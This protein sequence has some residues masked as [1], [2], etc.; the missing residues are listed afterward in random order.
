M[1][2]A[3]VNMGGAGVNMGGAGVHMGG[4]GSSLPPLS[5]ANVSSS[6]AGGM[7]RV[8]S[9]G[10]LSAG[11]GGGMVPQSP[12]QLPPASMVMS[13]PSSVGGMAGCGVMTDTFMTSLDSGESEL[14]MNVLETRE[15]SRV[16]TIKFVVYL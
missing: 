10:R 15:W 14:P 9:S 3:G 5:M 4:A 8:P 16:R 1:G 13:P 2:G 7:M 12:L 6:V 11:G